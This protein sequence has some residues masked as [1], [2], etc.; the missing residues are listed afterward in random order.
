MVVFAR[1]GLKAE[2]EALLAEV[3]PAESRRL[4]TGALLALGRTEEAMA[5]ITTKKIGS[6]RAADYLWDPIYDPVRHDPRWAKIMADVG[7]TEAH[8]RAQAWRKAHPPEK[9]AVK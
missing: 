7:L 8:A 2:A 3:R 9:P 4:L 1:A 6:G 5:L